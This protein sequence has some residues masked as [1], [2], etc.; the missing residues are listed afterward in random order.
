MAE[1]VDA[2]IMEVVHAATGIRF[3]AERVA[4][5][6]LRQPAR[7]KGGGIR[8]MGDMQQLAFMG[9]ILHVLPSCIDGTRPNG[10]KTEAFTVAF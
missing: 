10:E 1:L 8:S 2:A 6:R 7:L 5:D 9:A 3:D 4:K